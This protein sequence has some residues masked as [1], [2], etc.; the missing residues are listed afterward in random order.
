MHHHSSLYL[1]LKDDIDLQK[2]L[3]LGFSICNC[4]VRHLDH[5]FTRPV[6]EFG[7]QYVFYFCYDLYFFENT[8]IFVRGSSHMAEKQVTKLYVVSLAR[9]QKWLM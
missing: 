2:H 8:K 3:K 9:H 6:A 1:H 7:L 5:T 4:R